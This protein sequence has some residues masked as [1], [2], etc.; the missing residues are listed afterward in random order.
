[1]SD[2]VTPR[3]AAE[4]LQMLESAMGYLY[5]G[6]GQM[7]AG[8]QAECLAGL[9]RLDAIETATRAAIL[10]AFT[11]AQ[12]YAGDACYSS[13]TWLRH[14][15]RITRAAAAG[16]VGWA[17]RAAAHPQVMAALAEGYLMSE[18]YAREICK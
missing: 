1:M 18:S 6:A 11:A 7:A 3:S 9:E 4:A 13:R 5:T 8:T 17:R 12:G 10:D 15:T 14:Q 16:H 2:V